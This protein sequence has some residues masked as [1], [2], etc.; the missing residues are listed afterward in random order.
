[1]IKYGIV[2]LALFSG[3]KLRTSTYADDDAME[4]SLNE[5]KIDLSSKPDSVKNKYNYDLKSWDYH[6]A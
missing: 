2:P 5:F 4:E 6:I 1:M 3:Y